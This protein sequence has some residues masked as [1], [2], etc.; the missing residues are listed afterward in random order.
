MML[1][2]DAAA[3]DLHGRDL[4]EGGEVRADHVEVRRQV[5]VGEH[6]E[7]YHPVDRSDPRHLV[8]PR[9]RIKLPH[10]MDAIK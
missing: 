1:G 4:D 7:D 10:K 3:D 6:P 2:R 8:R 5:I 9:M